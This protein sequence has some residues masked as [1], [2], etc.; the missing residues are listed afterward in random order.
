MKRLSVFA[1]LAILATAFSFLTAPGLMWGQALCHGEYSDFT[2]ACFIG[3]PDAH[4]VTLRDGLTYPS[5][6]RAYRFRIEP[7]M[8]T[9]YIYLG[10]LWYDLEVAL[11]RDPPN[12]VEL[13]GAQ[14]LAEATAGE[15]RVLQFVRPQLIVE[16]LPP[17]GYTLF[18]RAAHTG[19]FDP[20]RGFTLRVALGPP[21]CATARDPAARYQ[22]ALSYQPLQPAAFSLLSFNAYLSPPYSDLFDFEWEIDGRPVPGNLRETLQVALADLPAGAHGEHHVRVMARGVRAYPDPDPAF[23]HVPPTLSVECSFP[24]P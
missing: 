8:S 16:Q 22:L 18:V 6:V 4:G 17:G 21:S 5:Q 10:D 12:E 23:R 2:T 15:R 11:W 9:A 14:L 24:A 1:P 13:G 7:E 19:S 3:S 20:R